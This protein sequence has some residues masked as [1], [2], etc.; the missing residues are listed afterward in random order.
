[1]RARLEGTVR[2]T[3]S[4]DESGV[5]TSAEVLSSSG[6]EALDKAALQ[7]V[8]RAHFEPARQAGKA[9]QWHLIIPV[10]FKRN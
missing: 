5:V 8:Q 1:M 10:R 9:V 4:I 6:H 7:A 3:A 2:I